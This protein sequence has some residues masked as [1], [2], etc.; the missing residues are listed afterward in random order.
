M[1][2]SMP[3]SALSLTGWMTLDKFL[4]LLETWFLYMWNGNNT[5]IQLFVWIAA[6]EYV[7]HL[8]TKYLKG[9]K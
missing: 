5:D 3:Y 4:D 8:G 1:T 6:D 9:E 2:V 7:K